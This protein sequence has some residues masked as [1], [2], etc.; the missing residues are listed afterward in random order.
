VDS[1]LPFSYYGCRLDLIRNP[2]GLLDL[3]GTILSG[4]WH[5]LVHSVGF[6]GEICSAGIN[7]PGDSSIKPR[8]FLL[9]LTSIQAQTPCALPVGTPG[10]DQF[11]GAGGEDNP[12]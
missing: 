8:I 11:C 6:D 2:T 12:A 7:T 5:R 1:L 3:S 10:S 9:G 4:S